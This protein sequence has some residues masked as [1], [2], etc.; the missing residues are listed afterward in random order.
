MAKVEYLRA[1]DDNTWDTVTVEVP[2]VKDDPDNGVDFEET[3][4]VD[5]ELIDYANKVLAPLAAHRK[6]V[7]FA[8]YNN[9]VG[10]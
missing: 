9:D 4:L 6:V 8:V 1:L 5:A 7:L 3:D 10:E 2:S